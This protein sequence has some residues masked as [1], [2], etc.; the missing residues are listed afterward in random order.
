MKPRCSKRLK[1][2]TQSFSPRR[3]KRNTLEKQKKRLT[4]LKEHV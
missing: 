4:D 2:P 1:K 3:C